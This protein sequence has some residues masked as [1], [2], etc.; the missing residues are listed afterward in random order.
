MNQTL[1]RLLAAVLLAGT[2]SIAL[3]DDIGPDEALRLRDSGA[4]LSFEKLNE[5]ALGAH[6]GAT[7]HDTELERDDGRYVYEV[8]LRDAQGL[9]WDLK[10]DAATGE[11]LKNRRDD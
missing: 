4:I 8:D 6:P 1:T 2:A 3:A 5:A 11:I 7:I 10:L 9:E